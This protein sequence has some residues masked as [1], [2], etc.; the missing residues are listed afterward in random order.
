ITVNNLMDEE[1]LEEAKRYFA[2]LNEVGP[3]AIIAQDLAV[4][5]LIQEMN[6]TN[7]PVHSSVMMNVHNLEMIEAVKALGVSRIVASREMDLK[8]AEV[9]HAKSGMEFEYFVHGDMCTVHG[10]NCLY[11]SMLFG[12]SSN[13]GR[14]M[15]PCRWDYRV[16]KDGYLYPTEYPLAAKDMY[17]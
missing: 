13:R 12:N 6:Y 5:P 11:S 9:L 10:A 1:D 15:K 4:F 16:K 8:T 17:M 2:F 7:I 3:D 14:C